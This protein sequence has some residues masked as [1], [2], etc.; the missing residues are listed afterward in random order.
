MEAGRWSVQS[1]F[2]ACMPPP[3]NLH[4]MHGKK[5]MKIKMLYSM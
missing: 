4:I 2:H 5:L 3:K 1:H